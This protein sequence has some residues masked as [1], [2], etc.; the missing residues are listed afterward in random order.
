MQLRPALRRQKPEDEAHDH[1][2]DAELHLALP[3]RESN[4]DASE[5]AR[6]R[7]RKDQKDESEG[8]RQSEDEQSQ[9]GR[10]RR[11]GLGADA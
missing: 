7:G 2:R 1:G 5:H 11:L 3:H 4:R 9:V 6:R 10:R 8:A